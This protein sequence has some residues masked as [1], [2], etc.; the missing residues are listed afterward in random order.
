[1]PRSR[2]AVEGSKRKQFLRRLTAVLDVS[3]GEATALLA[4][5]RRSSVRLNPLRCRSLPT[6][7]ERLAG[8]GFDLEP[9]PWCP[10]AYDLDGDTRRLAASPWFQGGYVYLQNASSFAPA[11]AL[12][13]RPGDAVLDV[14]ASPGGKASHVAA[15][16]GNDAELWLNDPLPARMRKLEEVVAL[17]GVR[18]ARLTGIEGQYVDKFIDRDFDRILLDAQCSGE[19]LVDLRRRDALRFWSTGRIEKYGRLQ[20][21][22]LVSSF[23]LLR[24]GGTLV[25]STCT[26]APEENEQPV[27]HLLRHFPAEV[28][29][30][31]LPVPNARPALRS[32]QGRTFDE[33]LQGAMRILPTPQMEGFFVCRIRRTRN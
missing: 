31:S 2:D 33:Q 1:M 9:I 25:Y 16:V 29:P 22:M 24:P 6:L 14:A 23:K 32:W 19:G 12:G 27:D 21:R 26:F 5:E 18:A 20:Q 28:V 8:D 3:P 10:D 17:L 30:F 15:M 11:L 13:A 4:Q 7:R